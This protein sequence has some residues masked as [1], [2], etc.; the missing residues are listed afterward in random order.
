MFALSSASEMIMRN[1]LTTINTPA[2]PDAAQAVG[3]R[4]G[5][6]LPLAERCAR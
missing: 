5:T 2:F 1:L 3:R 6:V 4:R